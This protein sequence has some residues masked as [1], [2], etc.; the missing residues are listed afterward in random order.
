MLWGLVLL[1]PVI[2]TLPFITVD[3]VTG[4]G[5]PSLCLVLGVAVCWD[6]WVH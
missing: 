1:V 2:F 6:F 4:A 5:I 3:G